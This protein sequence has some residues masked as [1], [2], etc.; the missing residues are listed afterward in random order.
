LVVQLA[1]DS[2]A[3]HRVSRR[4]ASVSST[5]KI[6]TPW[7]EASSCLSGG[8]LLLCW[9]DKALH[10]LT[11]PS[12]AQ[13]ATHA[14]PAALSAN[15]KPRVSHLGGAMFSV[16]A[17]GHLVVIK[18]TD[19][20][21]VVEEMDGDFACLASARGEQV[22]YAGKNVRDSEGTPMIEFAASPGDLA[23][24]GSVTLTARHGPVTTCHVTVTPRRD[25]GQLVA[26][27]LLVGEDDAVTMATV[28][29][30]VLWTREEALADILTVE[31]VDLPM[32]AG[33]VSIEEEFGDPAAGPVSAL[34][35]RLSTQWA[36]L[37]SLLASI[38]T[39]DVIQSGDVTH[40][41]R[42][43]FNLH[44]MLVVVTGCGK[45]LGLHSLT[46]D[47]LWAVPVSGLGPLRSDSAVLGLQRGTAHFPHPPLAA[48]VSRRHVVTFNP[49]TGGQLAVEELGYD[50][51]QASLM[52]QADSTHL[53]PMLILD[54]AGNAHVWPDSAAT[55]ARDVHDKLFFYTADVSTGI[56]Q[57]YAVTESLSTVPTWRVDLSS[58]GQTI[59]LVLGKSAQERV[60]SQGR[61][62]AD[63]SV[64]YKY[65]N[66]N[67]VLVVTDADDPV[68]KHSTS[69]Y[70]V[71]A[72][73]GHLVYSHVQ[74]RVRCPC[75]AV[76][77]ENWLVY[78]V[79]NERARR[80]ELTSI[81]LYEGK[82]Q[83]NASAFSSLDAPPQPMVEKQS[84][85]F[86][87]Q[88]EAMRETITEKGITTKFVM[89]YLA[90]GSIISI[91]RAFLDPRRPM[92]PGRPMLDEGLPP[93]MPEI[94]LPSVAV[95]NYNQ[96]LQRVQQL[97][98]A[99]SGLE[100]TCLVFV[101]G[102]DLF[103]TRVF[104]SNMFDQLKDDFDSSL[105]VLVLAGLITASVVSRRLSQRKALQHAWK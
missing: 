71:D 65:A 49:I 11:V 21:D 30:G 33:D 3:V 100:S 96:T 23:P 76:H 66:P 50:V 93:Y 92:A 16:A 42:D 27:N 103:H 10:T 6:T 20:V 102:L 62:L 43:R 28:G 24:V 1:A 26:R 60:H 40:L 68:H 22:F 63:R 69:A 17:G 80:T 88:I 78:S 87:T 56:L 95:V 13:F 47:V 8:E 97:V 73:T 44:K 2:T 38:L 31:V 29:G 61:V 34:L 39:G 91:N 101:H 105:I 7:V 81:E 104:P 9:D 89:F 58:Q 4:A 64:L 79:Y 19:S 57:G 37:T 35:K 48:L 53:K 90:S 5:V 77:S 14:L 85:I 51:S 94:P 82:V 70:L 86:P 52:Q 32:S 45:L 59:R 99:P 98:T 41:T 84:F 83:T 25:G 75:H 54:T 18:V 74:R 67:L 12:P 55:V 36:Q 72:V 46:G 15:G